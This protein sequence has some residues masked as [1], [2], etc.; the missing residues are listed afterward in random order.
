MWEEWILHHSGM[1]VRD[2]DKT[3]EYYQA[4]GWTVEQPA[5]KLENKYKMGYLHRGDLSLEF[6]QPLDAGSKQVE[7]LKNHGEGID[8][9]CFI[10]NDLEKIKAELA[11]KG[12]HSLPGFE[13]AVSPEDTKIYNTALFDTREGGTIMLEL[14]QLKEKS[15]SSPVKTADDGWKFDHLAYVVNDAYKSLIFY[16]GLGFEVQTRLTATAKGMP[17]AIFMRHGGEQTM[18]VHDHTT[19]QQAKRFYD[20]HGEGIDHIGFNVA[21]IQEE[22]AKVTKMGFP[23]MGKI[24]KGPD[25]Y[26]AFFD[27]RK[28][29][30]V[31]LELA[32]AI[33]PFWW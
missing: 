14:R 32:Q 16:L 29:G 2:I 26:R 25:A 27:T 22:A 19:W 6:V 21:N 31:I 11:A 8:H 10:V 4:M 33:L 17:L 5:M 13:T 23:L 20:T 28:Y 24:M 1:V 3:M 30:G 9:A 7:F 15:S 18:M 12:L